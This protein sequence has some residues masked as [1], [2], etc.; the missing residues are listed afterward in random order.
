MKKVTNIN[1]NPKLII[2][3]RIP[4]KNHKNSTK[5][6]KMKYNCLYKTNKGY[7]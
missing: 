1:I 6:Y 2:I 4:V 3:I 7:L 5:T